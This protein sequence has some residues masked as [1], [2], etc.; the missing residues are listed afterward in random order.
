M[1]ADQALDAFLLEPGGVLWA[2]GPGGESSREWVDSLLEKCRAGGAEARYL[3]C[4]FDRGGPWA[5]IRDLFGPLG[6]ELAG[7]GSELARQH[8]QEL[9]TVAP[10]LLRS[11][12]VTN[13]TLTDLAPPAE[14]VRVFPKDRAFRI[15]HGL[16]DLVRDLQRQAGAR[17]WVL[18][19]DHLD[20]AGTLARR[21]FVELMRREGVTSR[22]SLLVI[23]GGEP[24]SSADTELSRV[25]HL[26]RIVVPA[27]GN[28]LPAGPP[29]GDVA[30]ASALEARMAEDEIEMQARLPD[31]VYLLER[32]GDGRA[33]RWHAKAFSLYTTRGFYEDALRYG[34]RIL[35]HLDLLCDDDPVLRLKLMNKLFAC[36]AGNGRAQ[37]AKA[38]LESAGLEKTPQ[39]EHRAALHYMIAMLH[40]RF[41]PH[42]DLQRAEALL[43]LALQEIEAAEIPEP[44]RHFKIAFN[45]NGLALLRHFQ[46]R[47]DEAISLCEESLDRLRRELAGGKHRLHRSVLLF[48][49]AQVWAAIGHIDE[50]IA[51]LTAALEIDPFYTEY[52]N[53]RGG[54]YLKLGH[55]E[56]AYGDFQ[57][58]IELSPPYFEVWVN[59]AQCCR[60]LGKEAEALAAYSRA[61]DLEPACSL[62][63]LGRGQIHQAL[64]I[65]D[66][67]IADYDQALEL[68]PNDWEI[69][70]AR[71]T[72]R[73]DAGELE[74]CLEDLDHA[75]AGNRQAA[76]VYFN[77]AL[78]R[79]AAGQYRP[80]ISDYESYLSL[81]P[82]AEDR[83]EVL[84]EIARL[85][86]RSAVAVPASLP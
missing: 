8:G 28:R 71:G 18:A 58:A 52:Y 29:P 3:H 24:A 35:P 81:V 36:L 51:G 19:C 39:P 50:A 84:L 16:V 40:A 4:G 53:D 11:I 9:T 67:A 15:V 83:D 21:F 54:L 12:E 75:L 72:L 43:D 48:N 55:L 6:A 69:L 74:A 66:R 14:R 82:R 63:W 60:A 37:D 77:R 61:L 76:A 85:Q 46:G 45:R 5:G 49:I 59:L 34:E 56:A 44:D 64:G 7:R 73:F 78:A 38:I 32:L 25:A 26:E 13:L 27:A 30:A 68:Q 20:A 65:R 42:R 47:A 79:S 33:L 31:L 22:I 86:A 10:E 57:R 41:L 2:T 1:N 70:A 62:A 17:P 23:A 80:A